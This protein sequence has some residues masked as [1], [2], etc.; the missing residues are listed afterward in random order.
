MKETQE[1]NF[2]RRINEGKSKLRDKRTELKTSEDR[3]HRMIEEVEDYAIILLDDK[4]IIQNWNRGAE[5]IKLYSKKE[6]IGKSFRIFYQLEDQK[7]KLPELLLN[8][9][10]EKG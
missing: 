8:E 10:K 3:Y 2:E 5:K 6:I 1:E 7:N 4:G 9:A